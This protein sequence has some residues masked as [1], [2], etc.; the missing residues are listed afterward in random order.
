[1]P[2]MCDGKHADGPHD[3]IWTVLDKTTGKTELLCSDHLTM[4][5]RDHTYSIYPARDH[6]RSGRKGEDGNS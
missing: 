6:S 5:T 3:A 4:L 1:M 2:P